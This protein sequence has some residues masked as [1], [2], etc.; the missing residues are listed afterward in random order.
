V[1]YVKGKPL[2]KLTT[3]EASS[4]IHFITKKIEE[5]LQDLLMSAAIPGDMA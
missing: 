4:V 5:E 1:Q 3:A 2:N